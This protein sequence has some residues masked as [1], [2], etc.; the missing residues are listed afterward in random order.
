MEDL[1]EETNLMATVMGEMAIGKHIQIMTNTK[2]EMAMHKEEMDSAID[3][4]QAMVAA[5]VE[6]HGI[7]G[8]AAGEEEEGTTVAAEEAIQR[9]LGEEVIRMAAVPMD[10]SPL[11]LIQDKITTIRNLGKL[12]VLDIRDQMAVE[13]ITMIQEAKVAVDY[14]IKL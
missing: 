10:L 2:E 4:S 5:A 6:D 3:K 1:A 11:R 13:I 7:E 9:N 12:V 8:E 14:L